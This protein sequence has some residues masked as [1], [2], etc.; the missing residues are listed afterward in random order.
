MA[1]ALG[2]YDVHI[3]GQR[4]GD[5]I[6]APDW[7]DYRKR[8][9][10]NLYVTVLLKRGDN[11]MA[12]CLQRLGSAPYRQWWQCVF[13]KRTGVSGPI[14]GDLRRRPHGKNRDR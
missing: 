3:N 10:I 8:V 2:L 9:V 11:S 13:R 1:T 5:H 12:H 7:T 4:V 6:L 14:G